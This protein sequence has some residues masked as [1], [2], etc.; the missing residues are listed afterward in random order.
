M[1]LSDPKGLCCVTSFVLLHRSGS[2]FLSLWRP[3]E[4]NCPFGDGEVEVRGVRL[5]KHTGWVHIQ[6]QEVEKVTKT[7]GFPLAWVQVSG[8]IESEQHLLLLPLL[9]VLLC[10]HLRERLKKKKKKEAGSPPGMLSFFQL[11][12]RWLFNIM[13]IDLGIGE[14][15]M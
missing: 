9:N 7:M 6:R 2:S 10:A 3:L 5:N 1:L 13:H 14:I 4:A 8:P 11:F 12:S 15:L